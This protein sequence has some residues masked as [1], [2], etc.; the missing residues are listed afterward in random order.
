MKDKKKHNIIY[1]EENGYT[2]AFHQTRSNLVE[3]Q[4]KKKEQQG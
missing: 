2:L 1:M 4:L 3:E